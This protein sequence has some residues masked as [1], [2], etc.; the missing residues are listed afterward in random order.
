MILPYSEEECR[1]LVGGISLYPNS[2]F[3]STRWYALF[4][5]QKQ[6]QKQNNNN[7]QQ[8]QTKTK[9]KF[10]YCTNWTCGQSDRFI[11]YK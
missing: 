11:T 7:Q 3:S 8:Q 2:G 6:K 1:W 5:K 9:Q 10:F 4:K